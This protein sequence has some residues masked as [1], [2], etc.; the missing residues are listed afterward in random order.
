MRDSGQNR[1]EVQPPLLGT[2]DLGYA[3]GQEKCTTWLVIWEEW[4]L[5]SASES[6]AFVAF[7]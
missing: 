7:S 5:S 1:I 2:V 6:S 4:D 3:M